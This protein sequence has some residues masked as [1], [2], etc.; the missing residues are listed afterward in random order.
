MLIAIYS[1][2]HNKVKLFEVY[3]TLNTNIEKATVIYSRVS[4][5]NQR[6]LA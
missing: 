5:T 2:L 4:L 6:A 1:K 3:E